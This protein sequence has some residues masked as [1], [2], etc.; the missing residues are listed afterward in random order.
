M[1]LTEGPKL[2][3]FNSCSPLQWVLLPSWYQIWAA[4]HPLF[5]YPSE[6][7][8][9]HSMLSCTKPYCP[10]I[11]KYGLETCDYVRY[12]YVYAK[13]FSKKELRA[14]SLA[15]IISGVQP[16]LNNQHRISS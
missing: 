5:C 9:I 15:S 7:A 2:I 3:L 1:Q 16:P 14:R 13:L 8:S 6:K 4:L 12:I 10:M 11:P